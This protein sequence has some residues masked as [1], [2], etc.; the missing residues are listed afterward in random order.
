M[1]FGAFITSD[2]KEPV[3]VAYEQMALFV[4]LTTALG[5]RQVVPASAVRP[6][7]TATG[8]PVKT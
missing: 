6:I 5:C 1:Q 3:H 8:K 2:F 7:V 4:Y